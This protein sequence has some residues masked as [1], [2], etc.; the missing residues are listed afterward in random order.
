MSDILNGKIKRLPDWDVTIGVVRACLEHAEASGRPVPPDLR[1][2]GDW[3]RR[4]ADL[5]H[6]LDAEAGQR[7]RREMPPGRLLAEVTDPFALEV[8]RPV[9]P[10][11]RSPAF[12]RCPRTCPGS[13]TSSWSEVIAAAAQGRSGIAVLVGGSSTGKTRACWE[14][15]RLLRD[16]ARAVAAVASHRPVAPGG[17]A[18]RAAL[19]RP[20]D[21]HLAE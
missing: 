20:A 11:L 18:A 3:R 14:A 2:E 10:E 7:P 13:M 6:D 21:R 19:D 4:Y 5:E 8:H 12:R 15:L 17:G 9:Q 1:D 16:Q